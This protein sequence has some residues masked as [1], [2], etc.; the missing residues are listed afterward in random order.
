VFT[1]AG[2][3]VAQGSTITISS[4]TPGAV[5]YYTTDGSFPDAPE[6]ALVYKNPIVVTTMFTLS[7]VAR[8]EG[9]D[10]STI[11]QGAYT[12]KAVPFADTCAA[13]NAAF[14]ARKVECLLANPDTLAGRPGVLDCA[15]LAADIEAGDTVYADSLADACTEALQALPCAGLIPSGYGPLVFPI[16]GTACK[17]ILVGQRPSLPAAAGGINCHRNTQCA[18]GYCSAT[19][20]HYCANSQCEDRVGL[21]GTCSHSTQCTD[22]LGCISGACAVPG[23]SDDPC[24]HDSMCGAGLVCPNGKCEPPLAEGKTWCSMDRQCVVGNTCINGTC[25]KLVGA[26]GTCTPAVA[27]SLPTECAIGYWCSAGTCVAYPKVGESCTDSVACT[28]GY[29]DFAGNQ[30]TCVAYLGTGASCTSSMQC[31]S[32]MSS[33]GKCLAPGDYYCAPP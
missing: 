8:A 17:D 25:R 23:A 7:A 33:S 5:I 18:S 3:E 15:T 28:G 27:P 19:G 30:P 10:P 12:V 11:T 21:A 26:G 6:K 22:G 31:A 1:P 29:C 16:P 13:W 14:A 9:M 4:S 20:Q 32:G 24:Y 2:G